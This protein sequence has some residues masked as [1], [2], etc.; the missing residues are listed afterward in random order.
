MGCAVGPYR[1]LAV[2]RSATPS[3]DC[4]RHSSTAL[5]T[6]GRTVWSYC[7][8]TTAPPNEGHA[9]LLRRSQLY[10]TACTA[11]LS[12]HTVTHTQHSILRTAAPPS[13]SAVRYHSSIIARYI[14]SPPQSYSLH[15][16]IM[17][18]PLLSFT[19][20]L[21]AKPGHVGELKAAIHNALSAAYEQPDFIVAY[22]NESAD[23]ADT[24]ILY[25]QWSC[26]VDKLKTHYMGMSFFKEY[27]AALEPILLRPQV[28]EVMT[29]VEAF[30]KAGKQ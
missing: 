19:A 14:P 4:C 23:E 26:T 15:F 27:K 28:M 11:P 5:Q 8:V 10:A 18:K 21:T 2:S 1:L 16:V 7:P 20:R 6:A 24:V 13:Q 30:T 25:E 22:V 3:G 9:V 17:S 29:P 12:T